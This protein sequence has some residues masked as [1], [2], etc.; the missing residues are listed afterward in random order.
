MKAIVLAISFIG[1]MTIVNAQLLTAAVIII[2]AKILIGKGFIYGAAK[3]ALVRNIASGNGFGIGGGRGR[4]GHGHGKREAEAAG[5]FN[6]VL[7]EQNQ[8]DVD[9]CAKLLVCALNAK[10]LNKLDVSF[11]NCFSI[12]INW[13]LFVP[14]RFE[15]D[16]CS[17]LGR[18]FRDYAPGMGVRQY[19][20]NRFLHLNQSRK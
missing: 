1:C 19:I 11:H 3:G 13:L 9:E 6:A 10:P 16:I 4:G 14:N 8:K 18:E 7:L 12:V 5:D 17:R 15:Q 20:Q 2:G